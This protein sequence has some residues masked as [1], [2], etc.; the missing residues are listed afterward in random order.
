MV[1]LNLLLDHL[2]EENNTDISQTTVYFEK[3]INIL[4]NRLRSLAHPRNIGFY[5]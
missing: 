3:L 5:T 4:I 2:N 1:S